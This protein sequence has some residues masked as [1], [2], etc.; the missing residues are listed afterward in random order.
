MTSMVDASDL[1][2]F[3]AGT[4]AELG[5]AAG[6]ESR[7]RSVPPDR[8]L[9]TDTVGIRLST[10]G[11][12]GVRVGAESSGDVW[13]GYD[14]ISDGGVDE[15]GSIAESGVEGGERRQVRYHWWK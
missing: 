4:A 7:R 9:Y 12:D 2:G 15:W 8:M 1:G 11:N 13:V 6:V 10:S 3:G 14:A 5:E